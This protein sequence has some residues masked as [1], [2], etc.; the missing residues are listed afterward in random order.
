MKTYS[1]VNKL[2]ERIVNEGL[3]D[4]YLANIVLLPARASSRCSTRGESPIRI[5]R[6]S[7]MH[8]QRGRC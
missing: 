8:S 2:G 6:T 5:V 7:R 3:S 4:E 1:Y